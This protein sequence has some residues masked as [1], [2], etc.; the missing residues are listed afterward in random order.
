MTDSARYAWLKDELAR[1]DHAYYVLDDPILPDIEYDQFYRELIAIEQSHPDWVTLDSPSQRV[2]GQ[3][4][5]LFTEVKH[6]VPMLSL[7]N[8]LEND[9]AIAFDRRCRE[10]LELPEIN[11]AAELKFDGLAISLRY[12]NGILMQ[13]AT[14]G[15]GFSGEDVTA[16]IRTIKAIPLKLKGSHFPEVMDVRGEVFMSHKDF[17]ALNQQ[18][19]DKSEKTFANPRNAAAGSLRQL[20][21]KVTAQRTLSFYAYGIGQCEPPQQMPQSHSQLLDAYQQWGLPVCEHRA[22]VKGI[23]GLISFYEKVGQLRDQLPYD[24]DGVVYKVNSREQ[25]EDLGF[26][27]RAPRF[28]VAHKFPAQEALTTVLGID[29]QVGRTGAITPVARLAPVVVGGVTV[30]NATLHNED[31]V[32]RK[33]I[34][35]GDTVVVRRAGDVIPEV[36]SAILEKRPVAAASFIM[37]TECPVCGSHI[38]KLEGEAIA[39]CSGGLF[40]PAQRKQA[41]LHFA[42]RRAMDIEGLGEKIVDQLV[43]LQ[44]VRTPADLYQLGLMALANLERMG[45]KS[46]ENLL[47]AIQKSRS[48]TLARFIFALGIRH[49]G[50]STA[51]DLAKYFGS[52]EALMDAK[53]EDLLQ[54]NDVGPVVAK[55]LIGFLQESHNREVIEQLLAAGLQ[56]E[57]EQSQINPA[58]VGKTF[59]LTGTLPT[60]SRDQA[61]VLL[62]NAG[63]KVA[64]SVS[65]KTSY[66]VAG[67]E[68]GSKLEKAQQLGVPVID[69]AELLKLLNSSSN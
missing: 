38:E 3:A 36:V 44:I 57:V 45:E 33:D 21:P 62:E 6:V 9:E 60:M 8:A 16:N 25:Q 42:Q 32:R 31:E 43:D 67:E 41:L 52:I 5:N 12:E 49:V 28:A 39:R 2:S 46:A 18:A 69:E 11:Y 1:L 30:T 17:N 34:H 15:D 23:D 55:S 64:G 40:C 61:K 50:E 35:I 14:R 4:N 66:V 54:V 65:A 58:L 7:N 53:E 56:L 22:V 29:V 51:K 27:S 68:A 26:V 47:V 37:P 24:I 13:A 48:N 20:D 19:I 10:G 59:V 63:A